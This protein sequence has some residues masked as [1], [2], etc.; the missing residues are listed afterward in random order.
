[1]ASS[2]FGSEG[3]SFE[4][5]KGMQMSFTSTPSQP[6]ALRRKLMMCSLMMPSD[7]STIM[8]RMR[9][10]R[11]VKTSPLR[12]LLVSSGSDSSHEGLTCGGEARVWACEALGREEPNR[13]VV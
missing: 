12:H 6:M 10:T 9:S 11:S 8:T 3:H 1:M 13:D 4:S 7:I 2:I 5:E